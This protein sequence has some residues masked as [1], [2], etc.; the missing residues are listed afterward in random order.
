MKVAW[1]V[2]TSVQP[3]NGRH[4]KDQKES[5]RGTP[6][7]IFPAKAMSSEAILDNKLCV[8]YVRILCTH[9]ALNETTQRPSHCQGRKLL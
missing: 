6:M 9:K 4:G 2:E 5:T 1:V 8:Q 7:D 3:I